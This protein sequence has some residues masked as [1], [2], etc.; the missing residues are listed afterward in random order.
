MK[1]LLQEMGFSREEINMLNKQDWETV[2]SALSEKGKS[3]GG[4]TLF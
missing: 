4:C 2:M 3:R 1:E